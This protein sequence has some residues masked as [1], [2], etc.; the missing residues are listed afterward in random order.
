MSVLGVG[1][2]GSSAALAA[3][4][5]GGNQDVAVA[6]LRKSLDAASSSVAPLLASL[7]APSGPLGGALDI[8]M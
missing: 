8:R 4:G 2:S 3:L 7:P 5:A 6:M 1:N